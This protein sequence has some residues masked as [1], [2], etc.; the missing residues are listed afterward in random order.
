MLTTSFVCGLVPLVADESSF[1]RQ[2][3]V[4]GLVADVV[5]AVA[6]VVVFA[7]LYRRYVPPA[8]KGPEYLREPPA[9]LPPAIVDCLFTSAPTPAKMVA[10]L[11]DLVRR[12][13]IVMNKLH[14]AAP[15]GGGSTND[16]RALHLRRDREASLSPAEQDFVYELFDHIGGGGGDVLLSQLRDWWRTHPATAIMAAGYWG[17][18]VRRETEARGL[19]KPGAE[20]RNT[21]AVIGWLTLLAPWALM[22]VGPDGGAMGAAGLLVLFPLG[23]LLVA[24]AQ[25]VTPLT[26]AGRQLA[27]GYE[28]LRRYL[29][30]FGRMQEKTAEA[31]AIWEQYLTLAVVLG[32]AT[33][34]VDELYI[35]PPSF[36]EYGRAGRPG[37]RAYGFLRSAQYPD[38]AEADQYAAYRCRYDPTL[39]SAHVSHGKTDSVVFEPSL[40]LAERS[41]FAR[42]GVTGLRRGVGYAV[43]LWPAA[44][45]VAIIAVLMITGHGCQ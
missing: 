44:V 35:M 1:T 40:D 33:E 43:M 20:G 31:V 37:R 30:T 29:E 41:P 2:Q 28:A 24:W 25:R 23:A 19:L 4:A 5:I 15:A 21:L 10:T 8:V 32:L 3:F 38:A 22:F 26:D 39:P 36:L 14:T 16:D 45:A 18:Q 6:V 13:V 12:D 9:D 34:T 7:V 17:L 42:H 11:L 27:A